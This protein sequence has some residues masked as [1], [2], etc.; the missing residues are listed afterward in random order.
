MKEKSID[1]YFESVRSIPLAMTL[2]EVQALVRINTVL[3]TG[4]TKTSWWTFKNIIFMIATIAIISSVIFMITPSKKE[5]EK[6]KKEE[7]KKLLYEKRRNKIVE[8]EILSTKKQQEI[9]KNSSEA[10]LQNQFF[11]PISNIKNTYDLPKLPPFLVPINYGNINLENRQPNINDGRYLNSNMREEKEAPTKI[12]EKEIAIEGTEWLYIHNKGDIKIETWD[13]DKVM[14]QAFINIEVNEEDYLEKVVSEFDLNLVKKENKIE[15]IKKGL[16]QIGEDCDCSSFKIKVKG[17]NNKNE[18]I[19]VKKYHADYVLKVPKNL[20]LNIKSNFG[21][22]DLPNMES[23]IVLKSYQGQINTGNI[24][25][26]LVVDCKYG[27]TSLGSFN[28]GEISLYQATAKLGSSEDLTLLA[29]YSKVKIETANEIILESWQTNINIENDLK[30]LKGFIKFGDFDVE[31]KTNSVDINVIQA[32]VRL[33]EVER[34]IWKGSYSSL[35]VENINEFSTTEGIQNKYYIGK[36][37]KL[38]GAEKF[39]TFDIKTFHDVMNLETFQGSIEIEQIAGDFSLI[40]IN[41]KFT[42]INLHF[43]SDSKFNFEASTDFSS[44]NYS[45][46]MH[47]DFKEEINS[48]VKIRGIYNLE[49]SKKSSKVNLVSFR[50]KL[51]LQ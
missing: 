43:A 18:T 13:N 16:E 36:I 47:I 20:N 23:E 24:N 44:L 3:T 51:N 10:N 1:Q 48:K 22:I 11:F 27:A 17:K 33:K 41:S 42:N 50:G 29:K 7:N 26:K 32:N 15:I 31:G 5:N 8:N 46:A 45:S 40:D 38:N 49:N 39:S 21:T 30:K 4:Q 19:K 34:V 28:K 12:I 25:G 14:L 6:I 9:F 2:E 37:T 35:K